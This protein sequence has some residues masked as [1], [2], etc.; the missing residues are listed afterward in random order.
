MRFQVSWLRACGVCVSLMFPAAALATNVDPGSISADSVW[1]LSNSPYVIQG[2]VT[3]TAK[4]SIEAGVQ[5]QFAGPYKLEVLGTLVARGTEAKPIVFTTPDGVS[6]S[7]ALK[8]TGGNAVYD[9]D[10]YQSGSILEHVVVEKLGSV[11]TLGAVVLFGA[12]PYIHNSIFR[13]NG[14]S[15]IYAYSIDGDLRIESNEFVNN[16]AQLG[17]GLFVTTIANSKLSLLKNKMLDNKASGE[18][19]G[20][21]LYLSAG[22]AAASITANTFENNSASNEGGG[23]YLVGLGTHSFALSGNL[24]QTNSAAKVGGGVS[25]SGAALTM[26]ADTV[27]GNSSGGGDGGGGLYFKQ[28]QLTMTKSLILKNHSATMGGGIFLSGG[29]YTFSDNVLVMNDSGTHGGG[30]DMHGFPTVIMDHDVVAGN[31]A[32]HYGSGISMTEGI[33]TVTNS[34]IVS[35]ESANA[36][37]IFKVSTLQGNTI[38]YNSAA[39]SQFQ[40]S[41]IAFKPDAGDTD[42]KLVM[43]DNNIFR[44]ATPY[45]VFTNSNDVINAQTNWWG[46]LDEAAIGSRIKLVGTGMVDFSAMLTS[47][48]INAPISPPSS[49]TAIPTATSIKLQWNANPESDTQGYKV[50]WGSKPF[51][52]YEDFW[53]VGNVTSYEIQNL[54]SEKI[55]NMLGGSGFVAV[56]AYDVNYL[57]A[58]DD[59]ATPVNENQTQGH[60]SW[61]VLPSSTISIV[62]DPARHQKNGDL[63]YFHIKVSN[64][65][66][67]VGEGDFIVT[68]T[69][70]PELAYYYFTDMNGNR[71]ISLPTGCQLSQEHQ[72][73]CTHAPIP[74]NTSVQIIIPTLVNASALVDAASAASVHPIDF[75]ANPEESQAQV[76]LRV[77]APDLAV[78]KASIPITEIGK[79]V[80]YQVVVTNNGQVQAPGGMLAITIPSAFTINTPLDSRCTL[81]GTGNAEVSCELGNLAGKAQAVLIFNLT[82]TQLGEAIVMAAVTAA[83]DSDASNNESHITAK[84]TSPVQGSGDAD[85]GTDSPPSKKGGGGVVDLVWLLMLL[86][87]WLVRP[88][89]ARY[90]AV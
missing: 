17:G 89:L 21:G 28:S 44:N 34:A 20:G 48:N 47:L 61:Y 82:A 5:V 26:T 41:S 25:T 23:I 85:A 87:M 79:S 27:R 55:N 31:T 45:D 83:G 8:F 71:T 43:A 62:A 67:S 80:A 18:G 4:L 40:G 7:A 10:N 6:V 52:E 78:T 90:S 3:V 57:L 76:I 32:A 66:P 16:S 53:D 73:T 24:I 54:S 84:I 56:T 19:N 75:P 58:K 38:A 77:N 14:A 22:D 70:S 30:I 46:T 64:T 36:I 59:A 35:N 88:R 65:G 50:Y 42:A 74:P 60:E 69:I 37:G 9:G 1:S 29:T 63:V 81:A 15:G 13:N 2:D 39:S 11:D 33:C 51:P 86:S 68:H 72:V 49:I 12:E